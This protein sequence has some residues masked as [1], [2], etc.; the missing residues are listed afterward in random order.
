VY[1]GWITVATI[2]NITVFLVRLG[3]NGFGIAEAAWTVVVLLLGAGIGTLRMLRDRDYFYG[4]ALVWA[5]G[6][7]WLKHASPGGFHGEYP[8]VIATT[9]ACIVLFLGAMGFMAHRRD[10]ARRRAES[11]TPLV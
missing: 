8:I 3:W 10:A 9:I 7:I 6:G 4:A 5:Y 1:F 2:A 11:D